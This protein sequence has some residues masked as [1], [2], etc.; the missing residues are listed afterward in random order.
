MLVV[1]LI[2][3]LK[4]KENQMAPNDPTQPASTDA[5]M[6]VLLRLLQQVVEP[7]PP[8]PPVATD[9][10]AVI[11]ELLRTLQGG[12]PLAL[13]APTV[14]E[15][16]QPKKPVAAAPSSSTT[17]TVV[18]NGVG[19]LLGLLATAATWFN[20]GIGADA[21]VNTGLGVIAGGALNAYAPLINI[22]LG[23]VSRLVKGF[24]AAA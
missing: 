10:N 14:I 24:R 9:I 12:K 6:Q 21:A 13:P 4:L 7:P 1:L 20:G 8:P 23:F 22:G 16:E 2:M 18:K 11:A 3:I 5:L 17:S 15:Q 19:G